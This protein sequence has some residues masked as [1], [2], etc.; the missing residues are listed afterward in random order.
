MGTS[1]GR[2]GREM[3]SGLCGAEAGLSCIYSVG[4]RFRSPPL[5]LPLPS[6]HLHETS[7]SKVR[8]FSLQLQRHPLKEKSLLA[9]PDCEE[10]HTIIAGTYEYVDLRRRP[11]LGVA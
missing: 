6:S 11:S 10:R 8:R 9:V 3:W 7:K 5:P 4:G 2:A 1:E